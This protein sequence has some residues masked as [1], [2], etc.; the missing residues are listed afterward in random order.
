EMQV[1][2]DIA[3]GPQTLV[4]NLQIDGA[5]S[6]TMDQL[7]RNLSNVEG[8]PFSDANIAADRD[9]LTYFY[10]DRGFPNVQFESAA[11]PAPGD[12]QHMNVVYKITEGQRVF[13]DR[14]IVTGLHFTRPYIVNRQMRIHDSDPLSQSRMVDSQ[15]RL[16]SLGLFNQVDM[17]V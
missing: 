6:F 3:E 9:V 2:V 13:V 10:Y 1:V 16:Y 17:A 8:Q 14:V 11:S 15:R 12:P 7:E 4:H 5:G